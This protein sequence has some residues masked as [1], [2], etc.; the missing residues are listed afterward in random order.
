[1]PKS[2]FPESAKASIYLFIFS[3]FISFTAIK[4]GLW[5]GLAPP[6]EAACSV[7]T[8]FF[9]YFCFCY[10]FI[11]ISLRWFVSRHPRVLLPRTRVRRRGW[12]WWGGG[13]AAFMPQGSCARDQGPRRGAYSKRH[14]S[15]WA[16]PGSETKSACLCPPGWVFFDRW[17]PGV[18]ASYLV[19]FLPR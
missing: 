15:L 12:W 9:L 4:G 7:S 17:L 18:C 14:F 13:G 16:Q 11:L 5:I 6:R 10:I 2:L 1:M 8:R 19:L 3:R